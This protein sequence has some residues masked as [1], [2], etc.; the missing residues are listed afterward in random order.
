V[1][2]SNPTRRER[3][4]NHPVPSITSIIHLSN[5]SAVCEPRRNRLGWI[6]LVQS[7][8]TPTDSTCRASSWSRP[9]GGC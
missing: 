3:D 2:E 8:A 6:G 7:R 1:V 5:H 9:V 4:A